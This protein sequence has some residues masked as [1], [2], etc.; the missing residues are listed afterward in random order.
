MRAEN[1]RLHPAETAEENISLSDRFGLWLGFY[2]YDQDTYL[3]MVSAYAIAYNIKVQASDL[4]KMALEWSR[5]EEPAR[6]GWRGN[7]SGI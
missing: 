5:P 7:L 2:P 4:R 6:G 1:D 3:K